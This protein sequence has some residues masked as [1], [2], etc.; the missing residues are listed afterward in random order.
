MECNKAAKQRQNTG[1][2]HENI[3]DG[4][5]IKRYNYLLFTFYFFYCNSI[6]AL[7]WLLDCS[8][9]PELQASE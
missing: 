8:M 3:V 2:V 5:S 9:Q 4:M 7:R 1:L 6:P